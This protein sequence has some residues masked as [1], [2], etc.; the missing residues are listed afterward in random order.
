M[1]LNEFYR[2]ADGNYTDVTR[3]LCGPAVVYKFL[4]RYPN[5]NCMELLRK[6]IE[7]VDRE[8]AFRAAHTLKGVCLNL[9][10]GRLGK[11]SAR[12]AD[13]LRPGNPYDAVRV[14][15][16]LPELEREQN[17]LLKAIDE[18]EEPEEPQK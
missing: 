3:R 5:D 7:A 9:G 12:M 18:L 1:T 2:E 15:Q 13:I 4:R 10:L 17:R 11:L 8:A 16:L 14:I 6:G